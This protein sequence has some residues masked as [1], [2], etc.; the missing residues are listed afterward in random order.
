[1]IQ[2]NRFFTR[3]P[4]PAAALALGGTLAVVALLAGC[5]SGRTPGAS[6]LVAPAASA[7]SGTT[8]GSS[9]DLGLTLDDLTTRLNL[10]AEQVPLME[11]A[12]A[13]LDSTLAAHP[14]REGGG[15][16][17]PGAGGPGGPGAGPG[18]PGGPGAGSRGDGGPGAG[19]GGPGGPGAGGPGPDS[20]GHGGPGNAGGG[21]ILGFVTE[22]SGF[23]D[24]DRF[25]TLVDYL[26]QLHDAAMPARQT[27]SGDRPPMGQDGRLVRRLA[28][29]AQLDSATVSSLLDA[30]AA[31]GGTF[32]RV[33][34]AYHDGSLTAEALRDSTGAARQAL[35]SRAQSILSADAY[36]KLLE[37]S[38]QERQQ[39]ADRALARLGQADIDTRRVDGLA[40]ILGL[41][42]AA[43]ASV[44]S[45]LDSGRPQMQALFQSIKDGGV[46][47]ESAVYQAAQIDASVRAAVRA[48]LTSDQAQRLDA[49]E[50]LA[51]PRGA[52]VPFYL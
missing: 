38:A 20:S 6:S 51:P 3:G 9:S 15:P 2:R 1:M 4:A 44:A 40:A 34:R 19:P 46:A 45:A 30:F 25:V 50:K 27:Q 24:T 11:A 52:R 22:C 49:I 10:T 18:G 13:R 12:L 29:E 42:G 7:A 26:V 39:V 37:L 8:G 21:P 14:R 48:L 36:Q 43:K 17:G 41:D 31:A 28:Q 16:G 47:F 32:H 5:G 33:E 35:L 23:L